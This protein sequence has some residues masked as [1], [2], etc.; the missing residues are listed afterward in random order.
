MEITRIKVPKFRVGR[1]VLNEYELRQ[2]ML[3][4]AL[5]VKPAGIEVRDEYGVIATIRKD[6]GLSVNLEGLA[7]SARLLGARIKA[8]RE[9]NP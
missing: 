4:V 1:Y 5:G 6:G 2:L 8:I 9:L 3:D 7:I